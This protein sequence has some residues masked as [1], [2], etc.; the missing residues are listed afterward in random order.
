[1]QHLL[2]M[3]TMPR[4]NHIT[5]SL[6]F[7]IADL[8]KKKELYPLQENCILCFIG[9]RYS[10]F[11]SLVDVSAIEDVRTFQNE[12]VNKLDYVMP[13]FL[14]FRANP[15]LQNASKS[16]TVGVPDLVVEVWSESNSQDEI[17]FKRKLYSTSEKCE[18]WEIGQ[19]S[20]IVQ[21]KLG[22]SVLWSKSMEQILCT[23]DGLQFDL[24][25][26]ALCP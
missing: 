8:F 15:Y 22:N 16:K 10:G 23:K 11:E 6:A 5:M 25:H 26:L 7:G 17:N 9:K 19:N 13:D 2:E 12:I 4:H 3:G 20:N 24:R 18:F 14:Y 1:M 21:A